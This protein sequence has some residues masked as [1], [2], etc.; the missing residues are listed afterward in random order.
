MG[1]EKRATESEVRRE[2]DAR[3]ETPGKARRR[4]IVRSERAW[5][6]ELEPPG[7]ARNQQQSTRAPWTG[8]SREPKRKEGKRNGPGLEHPDKKEQAR[9]RAHWTGTF[10]GQ[11][12]ETLDWTIRG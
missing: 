11:W 5:S 6:L 7:R 4:K 8:A 2:G 10:G 1:E 12:T 3:T 9:N